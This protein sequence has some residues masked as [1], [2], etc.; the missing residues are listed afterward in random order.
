MKLKKRSLDENIYRFRNR[1]QKYSIR[2]HLAGLW[3]SR[4][5]TKSGILVVS[6]RGPFPKVINRG[7]KLIAENCQFYSGVRLEIGQKGSISIGNGTYLNRNTL[8]IAEEEVTIGKDC[9]ISWDVNIMDSDLHG[10]TI[11]DKGDSNPVLIGNK[12]WIGC[13]SIILKGVTIGDDAMVAAGAIVTKSVPER[14][15]VGGNP[16][17]ILKYR[18]LEPE[19][20]A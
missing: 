18:I 1:L 9:M 8:V 3:F 13:R 20:I 2:E 15:I 12:V 14:A 10:Q 11:Y 6:G 17:R 5:F 19:N 7:G 4:K 16:A